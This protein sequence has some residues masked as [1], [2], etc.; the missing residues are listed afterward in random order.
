MMPCPASGRSLSRTNP[1]PCFR[2]MVR[3]DDPLSA[4]ALRDSAGFFRQLP[5]RGV[6]T[7]PQGSMRSRI[8]L[9]VCHAERVVRNRRLADCRQFRGHEVD[10]ER[11][12]LAEPAAFDRPARNQDRADHRVVLLLFIG[13]VPAA[14]EKYHDPGL[15]PG[16]IRRGRS[17]RGET[18]L[19][20]EDT[21]NGR[22]SARHPASDDENRGIRI[23]RIRIFPQLTQVPVL[24]H[25]FFGNGILSLMGICSPED[26]LQGIH[27]STGGMQGNVGGCSDLAGC[28]G[29]RP[30]ISSRASQAA[31]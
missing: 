20:A 9:I 30:G 4:S 19:P 25:P 6:N 14:P 18:V 29:G 8:F 11:A 24:P 13:N 7:A 15:L 5:G 21:C 27:Y 31:A 26:R 2:Q 10:A 17:G 3:G 28:S 22:S 1:V 23:S 12:V 16:P